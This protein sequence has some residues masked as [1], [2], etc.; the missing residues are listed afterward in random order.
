MFPIMP[1]GL[2]IHFLIFIYQLF[3]SH[4]LVCD[5]VRNQF[6]LAVEPGYYEEDKFGIRIEDVVQ[7][8]KKANLSEA[9]GGRGALT[10]ETVTFAPIQTKMIDTNLL[11]KDE[12]SMWKRG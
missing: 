1:S 10:F 3:I 7:V 11:T 4:L 9:F 8:I 12:V 5:L 2:F 6:S